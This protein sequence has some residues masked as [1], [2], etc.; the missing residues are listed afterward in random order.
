[1]LE[2]AR[3]A[4]PGDGVRRAAAEVLATETDAPA[5]AIEAA[6]AIEDTGLAGAVRA[7]QGE[8]LSRLDRERDA[9][10]RDEAAKPQREPRDLDLS[11]TI[12]GCGD[13]V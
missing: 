1:M 7:D 9:V 2:G 8:E 5:A 6:D 12:S 3:D 10:E 11:H 13:T 4:E